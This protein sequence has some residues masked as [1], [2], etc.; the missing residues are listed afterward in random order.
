MNFRWLYNLNDLD[1][2]SVVF[3]VVYGPFWGKRMSPMANNSYLCLTSAI[4]LSPLHI[5]FSLVIKNLVPSSFEENLSCIN[6]ESNQAR[7]SINR[8]ICECRTC[9]CLS[10]QPRWNHLWTWSRIL[11]KFIGSDFLT[12]YSGIPSGLHSFIKFWA[13]LIH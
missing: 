13:E 3:L 12:N 2:R 1:F 7:L 9:L 11:K 10:H 6:L 8:F 4:F 5:S